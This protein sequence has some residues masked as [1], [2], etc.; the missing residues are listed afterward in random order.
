ML[1]RG[2]QRV[3]RGDA[4]GFLAFLD[5]KVP[6]NASGNGE[7]SIHHREHSAQEKQIS[8]VRRF[9][10]SSQWCRWRGQNDPEFVEARTY[11]ACESLI[12][13][14]RSHMLLHQLECIRRSSLWSVSQQQ[15]WYRRL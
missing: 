10:V 4:C 9:D 14:W 3:E 15:S 7:P 13:S 6:T 11:T 5:R 8:G 12:I 2:R 1:L